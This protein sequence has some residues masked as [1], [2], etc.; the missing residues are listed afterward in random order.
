MNKLQDKQL[1]EVERR[2]QV[3]ACVRA[4]L[5]SHHAPPRSPAPRAPPPTTTTHTHARQVYES[6]IQS[7]SKQEREQP[8]LLAKSPSRRRRIARG[9]GR[10]EEQ[11]RS[12]C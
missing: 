4:C 6:I 1:Q 12:L 2:Y 7:M 5:L 8:E 11:V 10:A 3:R 9:S